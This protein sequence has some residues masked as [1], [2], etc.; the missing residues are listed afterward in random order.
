MARR[1]RKPT[2]I[3]TDA[4]TF[5]F[6]LDK[7]IRLEQEFRAFIEDANNN[8]D[9]SLRKYVVDMWHYHHGNIPDQNNEVASAIREATQGLWDMFTDLM[10]NRPVTREGYQEIAQ[11][12][13][14]DFP[15]EFV[16]GMLNTFGKLED[17]E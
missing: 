1:G 9:W 14:M 12:H 4:K 7:E 16:N 6:K 17:G 15:D 11:Q 13:E 5:S 10:Q 3:K 2:G 8:P